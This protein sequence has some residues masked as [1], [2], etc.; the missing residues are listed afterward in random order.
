MY[1]VSVPVSN[2]QLPQ[3]L[4]FP[5]QENEKG[6]FCDVNLVTFG[7]SWLLGEP[8]FLGGWGEQGCWCVGAFGP[9]GEGRGARG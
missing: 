4:E 2:T 3:P 9:L 7:C 6:V 5:N 1:L 8:T